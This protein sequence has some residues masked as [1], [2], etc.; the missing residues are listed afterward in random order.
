MWLDMLKSHL[1]YLDLSSVELNGSHTPSKNGGNAVGYQ[2]RKACKTTNT[3][4]ISDSQGGILAI[5]TPQETQH[6]LANRHDLFQ[7]QM[8]FEKIYTVLQEAGI[9]LECLFLN[10]DSGF[11]S[12]DFCLASQKQVI[13]PDVK[14]YPRN[15]AIEISETYLSR[16]YIF[17][18]QLYL[19]RCVIEH[20][21]T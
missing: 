17:D 8:L 21:N 11:D 20:A 2:A 5:F 4:F 15:S 3:L 16:T 7:I 18:K 13:I 1:R 12:Q 19:D 9:K 10:A 6:H 14:D